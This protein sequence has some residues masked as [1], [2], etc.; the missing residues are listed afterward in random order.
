MKPPKMPSEE[1]ERLK[2]LYDFNIL[3]TPQEELFDDLTKMVALIFKVPIAL[4][5]LIDSNRQ[6][7]K[8]KLGLNVSETPRDIS[9]CGH[10]VFDSQPLIVPDALKDPRF[11]DNPLV[12]LN[13]K[14]RFYIGYPLITSGGH[15]IGTLCAIGRE[16][17]TPEPWQREL[18]ALLSKQVIINFEVRRA[19]K[20][21]SE[22][23][24]QINILTETS[25]YGVALLNSQ[26]N[27]EYKNTKFYKMFE[28]TL[29]ENLSNLTI[30]HLLK[31]ESNNEPRTL[32]LSK[33]QDTI[34]L[35]LGEIELIGQR[36]SGSFFPVSAAF[37]K[38]PSNNETRYSLFLK[39]LTE[40]KNKEVELR[41]AFSEQKRSD[42]AI[43]YI[44]D[45]TD[46]AMF[47]ISENGSIT[48]SNQS[49]AKLMEKPKPEMFG[50]FWENLFYSN[51]ETIEKIRQLLKMPENERFDYEFSLIQKNKKSIRVKLR[52]HDDPRSIRTKIWLIYDVTAAHE[53]RKTSFKSKKSHMIGESPIMK[54]L[55]R[56]IDKLSSSLSTVLI[57]GET[58]AGKELV[59]NALHLGSERRDKP[60]IAVNCA[61]LTDSI[62]TSQL[63]GH[64]KGAFTGANSDHKGFF[65]AVT[66]GTLFLDEI[67]DI[68]LATQ[69]ALLRVL[70][71]KEIIRVGDNKPIKIDVRIITATNR[72]LAQEV[73][74]GTFRKDLFYRIQSN[75]IIV[76]PLRDRRDDIPLLIKSFLSE[77][78]L[79]HGK[80]DIS[81]DDPVM[82]ILANFYWPGNVRELY[83]CIESLVIQTEANVITVADLPTYM[84][85]QLN[86]NQSK[87][88]ILD[89]IKDIT[90]TLEKCNGNRTLAARMLGISRAT[91]YRRIK[92]IQENNQ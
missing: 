1:A 47:V 28:H 80:V 14:I 81:I 78:R 39:D 53:L 75:K 66:G 90:N 76:P 68:S 72:D 7:F 77:Q 60:W 35:H 87:P 37:G 42:E 44:L 12:L 61:G 4:I 51:V 17:Q 50:M 84:T 5:S 69:S 19:F 18:L 79:L 10:V 22:R 55:Y 56:T 43:T 49:G 65:E 46:I 52:I 57:E 20:D 32:L 16:P 25:P 71:D 3:D 59:A 85:S 33:I 29:N 58:G 45:L 6:W 74:K 73:Q 92:N 21:L 24:N 38:F 86:P 15:S 89:T 41:E 67:G 9:F 13:P 40:S 11:H 62:L 64:V 2:A 48:F 63:F 34:N 8:S 23:E 27:I 31:T 83:G 82:N 54:A 36:K 91:L 30:F 26:F 88:E 70:Q